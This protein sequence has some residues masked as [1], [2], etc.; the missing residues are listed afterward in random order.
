M[1]IDG[2][3]SISMNVYIELPDHQATTTFQHMDYFTGVNET[4]FVFFG[5]VATWCQCHQ[6]I[7]NPLLTSKKKL[8]TLKVFKII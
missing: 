1:K 4:I 7:L 8:R 5:R 2:N 3:M 6:E